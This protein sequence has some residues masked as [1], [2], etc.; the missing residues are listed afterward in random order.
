[1]L[2]QDAAE[3][4]RMGPLLRRRTRKPPRFAQT[5]HQRY[6]KEKDPPGPQ[7]SAI[8]PVRRS[9]E[10]KDRKHLFEALCRKRGLAFP[11]SH[12]QGG[13]QL[14]E[15]DLSVSRPDRSW[16]ETFIRARTKTAL[17]FDY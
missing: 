1:M 5:E 14:P 15:G 8:A 4:R 2:Q 7:A 3:L 6:G 17:K 9:P 12:E 10:H 11:N 13:D 16:P